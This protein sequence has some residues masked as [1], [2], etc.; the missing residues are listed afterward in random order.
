MAVQ[1]Q[2]Y[3]AR[4][5][6]NPSSAKS[7]TMREARL[8]AAG[9][10]SANCF[11][12]RVTLAGIFVAINGGLAGQT[13]SKAVVWRGTATSATT[14]SG[15]LTQPRSYSLGMLPD[16]SVLGYI[17]SNSNDDYKAATLSQWKG[18]SRSKYNLPTTY[19]S[20]LVEQIS[21]TGSSLLL[22]DSDTTFGPRFAVIRNGIATTLPP[23]PQACGTVRQDFQTQSWR[24]N[25]NGQVAL[26]FEQDLSYTPPYN[27]S[28]PYVH[29]ACLWTGINW[30]VSPARSTEYAMELLDVSSNGTMMLRQLD[31]TLEWH[32]QGQVQTIDSKVRGYGDQDMWLGGSSPNSGQTGAPASLWRN[33]QQ[34]DLTQI[35]TAPAGY[36]LG[37]A[38]DS[39]AKG[40]V[41]VLAKATKAG[42]TTGD[43]RLV[44]LTPR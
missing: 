43:I 31:N 24:V 34:V 7:C 2:S 27:N 21:R 15:S 25:D 33:G 23:L 19:S 37:T 12:P 8:S 13:T 38:I 4:L 28:E 39:N 30:T 14:L 9:D 5:L 10:V 40:Q 17:G 36:T 26:L 20:W 6:S 41:L 3:S 16:S 18:S 32:A 29:T 42:A 1:A 22:T 11:F 35:S 44:L